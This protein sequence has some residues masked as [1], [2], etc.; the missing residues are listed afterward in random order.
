M[1][2]LLKETYIRRRVVFEIDCKEVSD[3]LEVQRRLGMSKVAQNPRDQELDIALFVNPDISLQSATLRVLL[4]E[5]N[6]FLQH[7]SLFRA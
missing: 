4:K 6:K 1:R 3:L 5:L 7:L 2:K